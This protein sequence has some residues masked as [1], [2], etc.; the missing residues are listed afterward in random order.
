[1]S[2]KLIAF[3]NFNQLRHFMFC[4]T[5]FA[6]GHLCCSG[7]KARILDAEGLALG[8]QIV[9]SK[10]RARDLMDGSFH[11]CVFTSREI[12]YTI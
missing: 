1:M 11:R 5:V 3:S 10:K 12:V 7:K 6:R 4:V 2:S 8:A 9:T